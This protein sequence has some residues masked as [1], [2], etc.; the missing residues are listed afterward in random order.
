MKNFLN[1]IHPINEDVLDEY[2][3]LFTEF[4]APKNTIITWEGDTE[5]YLYFVVEG[6]QKSYYIHGKKEHVI[7]FTYAPSLSGIPESFISQKPSKYFLATLTKSKFLRISYDNHQKMM[8]K[9][10]EIETLFRK[11][12]ETLLIDTLDRY[13]ELMAHDIET[14]FKSFT[15]RSPHLLQMVSQKDIA[16]YLRIDASNF[17]KLLGKVKI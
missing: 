2:L 15:N 13:Y 8:A 16:S 12:T 7:A 11:G 4:V 9:H 3:A 14:R 1:N 10:R 17:S 5:R 6:V